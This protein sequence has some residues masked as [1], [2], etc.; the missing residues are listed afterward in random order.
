M[1]KL[2]EEPI[3]HEGRNY[4]A[5]PDPKDG[6][7]RGRVCENYC[8]LKDTSTCHTLTCTNWHWKKEKSNSPKYKIRE[9]GFTLEEWLKAES[10]RD[11]HFRDDFQMLLNEYDNIFKRIKEVPEQIFSCSTMK[12]KFIEFGFVVE[13]KEEKFYSIGDRFMRNNEEVILTQVQPNRI[14][15]ISLSDGNRIKDPIEVKLPLKITQSELDQIAGCFE[16]TP[17]KA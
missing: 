12:K 16:L 9:G 7:P 13:V 2:P 1:T 6:R 15:L 3:N 10:C 4:I 17:I 14:C 5:T 11:Q 8:D